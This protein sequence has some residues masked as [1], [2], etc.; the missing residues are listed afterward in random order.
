M[1][2]ILSFFKNSLLLLYKTFPIFSGYSVK[3]ADELIKD[4]DNYNY[5]GNSWFKKADDK[6]FNSKK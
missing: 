5:R 1:E 6:L 4:P 3:D 2:K